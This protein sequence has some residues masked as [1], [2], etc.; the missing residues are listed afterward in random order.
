MAFSITHKSAL[1][2]MVLEAK[3][4]NIVEQTV[5][6]YAAH[7][8]AAKVVAPGTWELDGGNILVGKISAIIL[9]CGQ[10]VEASVVFTGLANSLENTVR[11]RLQAAF[12][13]L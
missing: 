9:I 13:T 4:Q 2:A 5:L 12:A 10:T 7:G 6:Q 8:V 1:P 3:V 11:Q